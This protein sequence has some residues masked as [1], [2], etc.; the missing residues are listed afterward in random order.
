V[1][2]PNERVQEY[3]DAL[4]SRS[5]SGGEPMP[6]EVDE[7]ELR[8]FERLYQALAAGPENTLSPGFAARVAATAH[9]PPA[10][11]WGMD[12]VVAPALGVGVGAYTVSWL[13]AR[14][15]VWESVERAVEATASHSPV[16]VVAASLVTFALLALADKR[17]MP[18][19]LRE[20]PLR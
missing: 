10:R 3:L 8:A 9:P 17:L 18:H 14:A 16:G 6:V 15:S 2:D 1:N 12:A 5:G 7:D 11:R 20:H 13:A 4:Y 19:R